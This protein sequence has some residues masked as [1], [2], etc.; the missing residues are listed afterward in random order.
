MNTLTGKIEKQETVKSSG[1]STTITSPNYK[2]DIALRI[3][4]IKK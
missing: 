4:R 1:V 2:E 3:I